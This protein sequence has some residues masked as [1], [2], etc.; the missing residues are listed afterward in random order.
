MSADKNIERDRY[1]RRAQ[2]LIKN[3]SGKFTEIIP[4][5]P[6]VLRT[7]YFYYCECINDQLSSEMNVLEIGAGTGAYTGVLLQTGAQVI[8]SDISMY[9]L[10]V[11][12]KRYCSYANLSIQGA[13][14][15]SPCSEPLCARS[16]SWMFRNR[17][18]EFDSCVVKSLICIGA[19]FFCATTG[20]DIVFLMSVS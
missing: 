19:L 7:P 4:S 15:E 10:D 16:P 12:A 11:L 5:I 17:P 3:S 1:D 18:P 6:R 8:A 14:M 2:D 20:S 9:S 13:D